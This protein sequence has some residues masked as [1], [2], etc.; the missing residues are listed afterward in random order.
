MIRMNEERKFLLRYG[1]VLRDICFKD[2]RTGE[3]V[4][5]RIIEWDSEIFYLEE[6]NGEV[7]VY[8]RLMW[9]E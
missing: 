7:F 5:V 1:T 2:P 3:Q 4:R 8:E 6:R 9:K